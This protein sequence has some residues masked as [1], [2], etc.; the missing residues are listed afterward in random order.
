MGADFPCFPNAGLFGFT[1]ADFS[2]FASVDHSRFAG[3]GIS[4]FAGA[5]FFGFE[6]AGDR[7]CGGFTLAGAG[8]A[9]VDLGRSVAGLA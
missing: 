6:G 8:W 5:G 9:A 2:R 3:A 1:R 4:G 7:V